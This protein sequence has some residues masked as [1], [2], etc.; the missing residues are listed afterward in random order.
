VAL[1]FGLAENFGYVLEATSK[2]QSIAAMRSLTAL[3]MHAFVGFILGR[4]LAGYDEKIEARGF[5]PHM[6]WIL[7]APIILHGLYDLPLLIAKRGLTLPQI[8]G[9]IATA[10]SINTQVLLVLILAVAVFAIC[11]I[12]ICIIFSLD[13]LARPRA[14][15]GFAVRAIRPAWLDR[16]IFA[17]WTGYILGGILGLAVSILFVVGVNLLPISAAFATSATGL[18]FGLFPL[19][20]GCA[21]FITGRRPKAEG[22]SADARPDMPVRMRRPWKPAVAFLGLLGISAGGFLTFSGSLLVPTLLGVAVA[23]TEAGDIDTAISLYDIAEK[24]TPNYTPIYILRAEAHRRAQR[25]ARALGDIDKAL[26]LQP[27]DFRIIRARAQL[28]VSMHQYREAATDLDHALAIAPN[29][30]HLFAERATVAFYLGDAKL[31]DSYF[32]RAIELGP[33]LAEIHAS[34]A[35]MLV[36]SSDTIRAAQELDTALR[37][38]PNHAQ[39]RFTR[40]RLFYSSGNFTEAVNELY[41]T[42]MRQRDAYSALWLHLARSQNGQ[43]DRAELARTTR[44]L[45]TTAWPAPLT[46]LYLGKRSIIRARFSATNAD[47][48]CEADFYIGEYLLLQRLENDAVEALKRA[49]DRCP[50][51][52][53]ERD[54]AILELRR[55]RGAGADAS[56]SKPGEGEDRRPATPSLPPASPKPDANTGGAQ[57]EVVAPTTATP[58]VFTPPGPNLPVTGPKPPAI[59]KQVFP[60]GRYATRAVL[61]DGQESYTGAATWRAVIPDGRERGAIESLVEMPK[62]NLGLTIVLQRGKQDAD[63]VLAIEAHALDRGAPSSASRAE[64]G[65]PILIGGKSPGSLPL[66]A[67]LKLSAQGFYQSSIAPADIQRTLEGLATATTLQ[68]PLG[69]LEG[70]QWT[71]SLQLDA[72]TIAATRRL[73]SVWR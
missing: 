6:L 48:V 35:S 60:G 8:L 50:L 18:A 66:A 19:T 59:V 52:F 24:H 57:P 47:E 41:A 10:L 20:I 49:A 55:L 65:G 58:Y 32:S 27:D 70:G 1:G 71:L 61:S 40:G 4:G 14:T 67:P 34:F 22:T 23:R 7:V 9:T 51:N 39:A 17:S 53:I 21:L 13:R 72:P 54:A 29:D 68:I 45:S 37:L 26:A 62:Q 42:N 63:Y 5:R 36:A 12:A 28:R 43:D 2:W 46:Q 44:S 3:P 16:L 64:I 11:F 15:P 69:K 33:K 30:P 31:A 38:D 73:I 25:Y 56:P